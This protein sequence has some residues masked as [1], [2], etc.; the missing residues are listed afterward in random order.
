MSPRSTSKPAS[1]R[2][3]ARLT[4]VVVLPTPPFWLVTAMTRVTGLLSRGTDTSRWGG[5]GSAGQRP[6]DGLALPPRQT[7]RHGRDLLVDGAHGVI[8]GRAGQR[9][10]GP[11]DQAAE[12]RHGRAAGPVVALSRSPLDDAVCAV[13]EK[14]AATPERLPRREGQAVKRPLAR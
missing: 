4:A 9:H 7:L 6:L 11:G 3:A 14:V 12:L 13:Y 5:G 1:A 2:H 8:E 10:D